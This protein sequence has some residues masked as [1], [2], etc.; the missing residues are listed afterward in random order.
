MDGIIPTP[1][2]F[3]LS[4]IMIQALY[5]FRLIMT[6]EICYIPLS[7][8]GLLAD[9]M[10]EEVFKVD[11]WLLNIF[12]LSLSYSKDTRAIQS[13]I[14]SFTSSPYSLNWWFV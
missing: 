5:V 13:N 11:N 1:Q 14:I 4:G 8:M 6:I 12:Q 9:F 10:E 2:G 3:M 7:I